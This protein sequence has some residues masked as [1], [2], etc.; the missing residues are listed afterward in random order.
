MRVKDFLSANVISKIADA[1]SRY[2]DDGCDRDY[3]RA[4]QQNLESHIIYDDD[5][6]PESIDF[7]FQEL[8]WAY[9]S[10]E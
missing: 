4:I 5:L 8:D 6:T 1:A 2:A 7:I 9:G 10:A 3:H